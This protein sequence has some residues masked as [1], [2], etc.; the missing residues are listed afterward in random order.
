MKAI[1]H[2]KYSTGSTSFDINIDNTELKPES[3]YKI[4]SIYFDLIDMFILVNPKERDFYILI[5]AKMKSIL[6]ILTQN[7]RMK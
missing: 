4:Q 7:I 5:F 6:F 1:P 3:V 2:Q